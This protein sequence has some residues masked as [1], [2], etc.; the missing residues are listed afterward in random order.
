MS[1]P[2]TVCVIG[3]TN[4]CHPPPEAGADFTSNVNVIA[5]SLAGTV[6]ISL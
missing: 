3:A 4:T 6:V 5:F 2:V 1:V